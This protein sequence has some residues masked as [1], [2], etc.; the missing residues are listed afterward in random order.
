MTHRVCSRILLVS[1]LVLTTAALARADEL[2]IKVLSNR[3]D[4][5]SGGDALVEIV[6]PPDVPASDVH[7]TLNGNDVTIAFG[8]RRPDGPFVGLVTGLNAGASG[9]QATAE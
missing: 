6:I 4:L 3:A 7:V 5:V 8:T 1:L 9:G 2:A